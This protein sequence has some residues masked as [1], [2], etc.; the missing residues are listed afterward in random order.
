MKKI[1]ILYHSGGE[2]ANQLWNYASIYAYAL[3]R[4]IELS[5]PS[6]Y[7][8]ASWFPKYRTNKFFWFFFTFPFRKDL[9]RKNALKR[10]IWRKVYALYPWYVTHF[11]KTALVTCD[12]GKPYYLP[13]TES[14]FDLSKKESTSLIY[15][16]GW[17]FRNPEGLKKY[18]KEIVNFFKPIDLVTQEIDKKIAH[19]R[20]QYHHV[21]GVH[22]RQGDY[23][24]WQ[25]GKYFID[26]SRTRKILNEYL[27]FTKH[28]I[29]ETL[30]I[31]TSDGAVNLLIFN[32]LNV[33]QSKGNAIEDIFL[34]S[35]TDII[36][37]S[38]STYGDFAAYY[39]NIPHV[40]MTN[41]AVDW[42]YY[43]DKKNYFMG[44]YST[45]VHF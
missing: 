21:V 36:I 43:R 16:N 6:F 18:H 17:L 40:V 3:E 31:I 38:D 15:F 4:E 35:K 29:S 2:L 42:E 8:Y 45:W 13:P 34:L 44:K 39:G 23:R 7:E 12:N 37:G 30:F 28:S 24:T 26:E 33:I 22:I 41:T 1:I 11:K 10:R 5:N 32:G 27:T 19:A 25:K 14:P 9:K 20:A